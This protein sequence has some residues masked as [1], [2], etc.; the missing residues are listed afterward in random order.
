MAQ[1]YT[2]IAFTIFEK[3]VWAG[4]LDYLDFRQLP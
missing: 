3:F 4:N 1:L 2:K